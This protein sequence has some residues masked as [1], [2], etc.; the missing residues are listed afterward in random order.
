MTRVVR[1]RRRYS[2][3]QRAFTLV[4]VLVVIAI[5]GILVAILLPAVQAARE[6]ARKAQC[7]SNQKQVA[8]GV[9]NYASTGNRLPA[10]LHPKFALKGRASWRLTILPYLDEQAM[11]DRLADPTSW[12]W[13]LVTLD[14]TKP[15]VK[16]AFVAVYQCPASPG[17]P[18]FLSRRQIISKPDDTLVFDRIAVEHNMSPYQVMAPYN[19]YSR[20]GAWFGNASLEGSLDPG[21]RLIEETVWRGAKLQYITDGLSHTVLI[22]EQAGTPRRYL[23]TQTSNFIGDYEESL[24]WFFSAN[25]YTQ[26]MPSLINKENIYQIFAFHA[27][28]AHV[29]FCDGAVQFL[30]DDISS[31]TLWRLLARD[32]GQ[33]NAPP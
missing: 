22:G 5:I 23:G 3:H 16:P 15:A 25:E 14:E 24:S 21:E 18:A 27:G 11:F 4:E 8:L 32:D 29:A 20:P 19:V 33:P 9:L 13:R 2:D 26:P 1:E 28:G 31:E 17:Y 6:A 10:L 12:D 30:N 7:A